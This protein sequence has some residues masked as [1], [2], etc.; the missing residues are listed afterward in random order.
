MSH[1]PGLALV[2]AVLA[3]AAGCVNG[4]LHVS[5]APPGPPP[6]QVVAA[7]VNVVANVLQDALTDAGIVVVEKRKGSQVRLVGSTGADR[8]FAIVLQ[9]RK[10]AKRDLTLVIV[11]C[12][13]DP[14]EHFLQVVREALAPMRPGADKDAGDT[15]QAAA[16]SPDRG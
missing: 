16:A 7:S 12:G 11:D 2:G 14:D 6:P 3:A 13:H 8:L 10:G 4:N 1:R 9:P 15:D 5:P